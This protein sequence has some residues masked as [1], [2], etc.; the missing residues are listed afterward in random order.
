MVQIQ[1]SKDP[2]IQLASNFANDPLL[3][4][5]LKQHRPDPEKRNVFKYLV[6]ML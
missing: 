2:S 6:K 3:K 4:P 1:V 5:D